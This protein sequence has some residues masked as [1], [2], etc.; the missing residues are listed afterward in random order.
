MSTWDFNY[1]VSENENRERQQ[2]CM[3]N[4]DVWLHQ[5]QLLAYDSIKVFFNFLPLFAV[6]P[7]PLQY[8]FQCHFVLWLSTCLNISH[9]FLVSTWLHFLSICCWWYTHNVVYSDPFVLNDLKNIYNSCP[10]HFRSWHGVIRVFSINNGIWCV[11]L[12]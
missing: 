7:T 9:V 10:R 3:T 12:A 8:M 6:H 5:Q 2:Y 4:P 11:V 1:F